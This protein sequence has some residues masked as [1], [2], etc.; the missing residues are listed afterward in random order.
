MAVANLEYP[1][2]CEYNLW[3]FLA[4]PWLW[5]W[6]WVLK[7]YMTI[8]F[9]HDIIYLKLRHWWTGLWRWCWVN[10]CLSDYPHLGIDSSSDPSWVSLP[11]QDVIKE[12]VFLSP[13]RE[14][15][16]FTL[17]TTT[18]ALFG[19]NCVIS[20][21]GAIEPGQYFVRRR[22]APSPI[23]GIATGPPLNVNN[24]SGFLG[25]RKNV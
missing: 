19:E 8:W 10:Q 20:Q 25:K 11:H 13:R 5:C 9:F 15:S 6:C 14:A 23:L 3:I 4:V 17:S 1:R 22:A 7:F 16:I 18:V 21:H 2:K 12:N 24:M